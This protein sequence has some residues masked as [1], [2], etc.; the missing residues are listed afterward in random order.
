M[1]QLTQSLPLVRRL[2]GTKHLVAG[3]HD[4]PFR[5]D[6]G[7][8]IDR[9]RG[10]GFA[11]VVGG[12]IEVDL[13]GRRV[14]ASHFPYEGDSQDVERYEQHRPHDDGATFLLHGHVHEKWRQRGRMVNVGVDAWAGR[15]VED[16][17]LA[18]V[19]AAGSGELDPLPWHE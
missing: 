7:R 2:H 18:E 4:R 12:T 13:A 10:V 15:P 11:D 5:R 17:V 8:E 16:T 14:L 9:Y 6:G 1:G 19:V 3:N